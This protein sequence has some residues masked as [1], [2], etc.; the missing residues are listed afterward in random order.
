MR[1]A[2]L[3]GERESEMWPTCAQEIKSLMAADTK[4]GTKNRAA[5]WTGRRT[6]ESGKE[7]RGRRA[8]REGNK[9]IKHEK[10]ASGGKIV[11]PHALF[12]G[13]RKSAE[14]GLALGRAPVRTENQGPSGRKTRRAA[15]ERET[16]PAELQQHEKLDGRILSWRRDKSTGHRSQS[17]TERTIAQIYHTIDRKWIAQTQDVKTKF[18]LKSKYDS[19]L[20][21]RGH[22]TTSLI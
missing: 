18:S 11:A 10:L 2:L 14:A 21:Y 13:K 19:Y 15:P 16:A 8:L 5:E 1:S 12:S 7:N 20:K 22:C 4:A 6:L 3:R 9:K 17:R